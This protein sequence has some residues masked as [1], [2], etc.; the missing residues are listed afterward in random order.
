MSQITS[1]SPNVVDKFSLVAPPAR[2][3]LESLFLPRSAAVIGATDRPGTVGRSVLSN[4][5]AGKY[6]L[7]VYAVNPTHDEILGARTFKRIGDIPGG[8]DLALV[9]TPAQTV[10]PIIG[11]CVDAGVKSVVVISAGFREQGAAGAVLEDEI[12]NHLRRGSLRLIGPLNSE[13][14]KRLLE[15]ADKC[16]VHRTLTVGVEIRTA[17]SLHN[18]TWSIENGTPCRGWQTVAN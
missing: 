14:R 13:Q 10:P 17:S 3:G 12:Q 6:P 7:K 18:A 1:S 11:E 15:I 16:P 9:V 2:A 5:L 8:V 4:L